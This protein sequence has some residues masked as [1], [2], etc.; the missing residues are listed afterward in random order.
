[1]GDRAIDMTG[2]RIGRLLVLHRAGS[3]SKG[4]SQ[5]AL[6]FCLCDCGSTVEVRGQN[7]RN[8]TTKSCN[9]LRDETAAKLK[10]THG[11]SRSREYQAWCAIKRRC[12][13]PNTAG[14]EY[15]GA[16]GITMSPRWVESFENFFADVGPRPPC[17]T[18]HAFSIDRIN[19]NGNYEPGNVRWATAAMQA[20]NRRPA[21]RTSVG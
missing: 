5:R 18:S 2:A 3:Y 12:F 15:Y 10:L 6:W 9:C 16:R 19:N 17:S 11:R 20:S 4:N 1:M 8:G 14:Y 7:L 13:A 21:R